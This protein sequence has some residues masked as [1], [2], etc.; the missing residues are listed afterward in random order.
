M[1]HN[2]RDPSRDHQHGRIYRLTY[3]GRPLVEHAKIA[4]EPIEKLL[5]LLKSKQDRVRYRARIELGG[6]PTAEV[7]TALASWM[8][9]LDASDPD[10]EHHALEGLWLHQNH[11]VVNE[12]LLKKVLNSPDFRARAA[13]TRVLCYWRDQ[14][15]NPLALLQERV[16][17]ENHRVRLEAVR[18]L[19]FFDSDEALE[20]AAE[21]LIHPQDDYLAYVL[22]ETMNTLERRAQARK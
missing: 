17:D 2:L 8:S 12:E 14:V 13:A 1:Q 16:N 10:Y 7:M 11:N 9:G 20:I 18:A 6:R 3:D 15:E 4:G 22:K 19:S 5:D 21:S